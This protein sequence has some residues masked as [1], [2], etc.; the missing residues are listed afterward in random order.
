[1]KQLYIRQNEYGYGYELVEKKNG[2]YKILARSSDIEK[3][4]E[5][6]D[7]N[8]PIPSD[9]PMEEVKKILV[10]DEKF[11]YYYYIPTIESL[12]K[13]AIKIIKGYTPYTPKEPENKSGISSIEDLEKMGVD[14]SS[15]IGLIIS[16]KF[17]EYKKDLRYYKEEVEIQN[18]VK[19][20]HND[21]PVKFS[22]IMYVLTELF[23][24]EIETL[25]EV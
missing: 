23:D 19:K 7:N 6:K 17:K 21:E 25:I 16:K 15:E 10:L 1:M 22:Y 11:F 9:L 2:G 12:Q 3:L 13:V 20:I 5:I 24:Y 18:L 4:K 14:K 8:L